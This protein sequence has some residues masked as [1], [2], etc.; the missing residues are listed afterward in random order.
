[1]VRTYGDE[2]HGKHFC[3]KEMHDTLVNLVIGD[4]LADIS[5]KPG[6][7]DAEYQNE[8]ELDAN[9]AHV[10]VEALEHCTGRNVAT[11]SPGSSPDLNQEC[12]DIQEYKYKTKHPRFEAPDLALVS[13]VP[14]HAPKDHVRKGI[15][16][17]RSGQQKYK[18]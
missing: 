18:P 12:Q 15:G 11:S 14:D 10:N 17:K 7:K 13:I 16:P 5:V 1:M 8:E 2:N 4:R 9:A 6:R 3:V